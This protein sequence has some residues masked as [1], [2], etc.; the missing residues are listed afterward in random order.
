MVSEMKSLPSKFA[1]ERDGSNMRLKATRHLCGTC[2]KSFTSV[3]VL[4]RHIVQEHP[5]LKLPDALER[6]KQVRQ[7]S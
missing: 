5:R 7:A 4:R 2:I 1:I 6:R 3:D